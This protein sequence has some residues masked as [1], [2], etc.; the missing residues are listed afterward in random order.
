[1]QARTFRKEGCFDIARLRMELCSIGI[2]LLINISVYFN[3]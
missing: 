2:V 1:M 3:F